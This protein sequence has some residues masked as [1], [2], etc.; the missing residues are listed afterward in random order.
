MIPR[1]I[2]DIKTD[3]IE[4]SYE[5]LILSAKLKASEITLPDANKY[6]PLQGGISIGPD[7]SIDGYVYAGTLGCFA[8]DNVT[9]EIL[10]LSNFHVLCVDNNSKPSDVIDQPSLVDRNDHS[11]LVGN[12]HNGILNADID[13]A[14]A[15]VSEAIQLEY[16]IVQVGDLE[17]TGSG[18]LGS[19]AKKRGRTTELTFG[20]IDAIN[21]SV[22]IDYGNGLGVRTLSNQLQFVLTPQKMQCLVIMGTQA[23]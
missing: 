17:G 23:L 15:S 16:S 19:S 12:L 4:G 3:V 21:S 6:R 9:G 14:V 8:K 2:G 5:S 11:D 18:L 20:F 13:A 1:K 10:L 7:R 22:N